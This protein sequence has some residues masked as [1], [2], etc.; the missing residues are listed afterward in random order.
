M[1]KLIL[2]WGEKGE[3]L[4]SWRLSGSQK[5]DSAE[6]SEHLLENYQLESKEILKADLACMADMAQSN[7]VILVLS[8][9][10]VATAQVEVPKKAQR[11]LR[12]AVPYI[13]EDEIAASVDDLFLQADIVQSLR[14]IP[15]LP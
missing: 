12:K 8:S 15:K 10:D 4:F 2:F 14:H 7:S 6:S 11:L 3:E 9:I 5:N 1:A 13:L